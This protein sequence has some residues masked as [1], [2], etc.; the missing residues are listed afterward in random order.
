MDDAVTPA[1]NWLTA[2]GNPT[3]KWRGNSLSALRTALEHADE[4]RRAKAV[5]TRSLDAQI[6]AELE[7]ARTAVGTVLGVDGRALSL[8]FWTCPESPTLHCLYNTEVDRWSD[9]CLICGEPKDRY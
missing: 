5:V 7:R 8:G 9:T 2:N 4:Y 3:V 1:S 6:D